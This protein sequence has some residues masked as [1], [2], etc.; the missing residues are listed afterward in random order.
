MNGRFFDG[1]KVCPLIEGVSDT[2]ER[3]TQ[4]CILVK[5]DTRGII[6]VLIWRIKRRMRGR[7]WIISL[8]GW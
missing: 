2:D 6:K 3:S 8:S 4:G 5:R 7:D 1:R